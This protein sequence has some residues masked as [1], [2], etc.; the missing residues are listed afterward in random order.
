MVD[1]PVILRSL[2]FH[3]TREKGK[4]VD[5]ELVKKEEE[6]DDVKPLFYCFSV[7]ENDKVEN[8]AWS[9]GDSVNSYSM[10]GDVVYFD[11]TYRSITSDMLFGAW[12]GTDNN[13]RPIFF[14]C[15][16]LQDETLRSFAWAFQTL[17]LFMKGRCPQ[18]IFTD[19]DPGLRD[20]IRSEL[21]SSKHVT[22]IWNI[23][24]KVST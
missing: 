12:I 10:F 5:Q 24:P 13:G 15:V 23:L 21:P 4:E 16:L 7:D 14:G 8:I 9:Y 6:E 11:T 19:L 18:K 1:F 20:A 3:N 17:I 2:S 22:S